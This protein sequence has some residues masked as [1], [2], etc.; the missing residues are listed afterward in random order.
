[1]IIQK[2][3]PRI[4]ITAGLCWQIILGLPL[5][6]NA[7]E[8]C[9]IGVATGKATADGRPL[10]WKT[11]DSG[12]Q[13]DNEV[14]YNS[15]N[16]YN[17]ISVNNDGAT[18]AWMG[19]N[20]KGFAIINSVSS[21][22]PGLVNSRGISNGKIMRDCLGSCATVAEFEAF[23]ILTNTTGRTSKANFGVIDS[24]GA[25]VI[26]ETSGYQFW[27]F[28]ANDTNL[29]KTGYIIRTNFSV[30]GGGTYSR[31]RFQRSTKLIGDFYSGD[32]LN[33]RSI[34]RYQ[35]RNFSDE[36]SNPITV[37]FTAKWYPS[38]SYRYGYLYNY[39]SI[40]RSTSVSAM[41]VQGVLPQ[42][43]PAYLSTMWTILGQP[44][45]GIAVPYWPVGT[46]PVVADGPVTAELCDVANEIR[47]YLYDWP[48]YSDF[49]DSYKLLDGSSGGLWKITLPVEDRIL[50]QTDSLLTIWRASP[51]VSDILLASETEFA[52]LAL[53]TLKAGRD[54]LASLSIVDFSGS[55]P[56][57]FSLDQN[58]PNPFNATT[59]IPFR[60]SEPAWITIKIHDIR[61]RQLVTLFEGNLPAGKYE[62]EWNSGDFSSGVYLYSITARGSSNSQKIFS[63]TGKLTLIK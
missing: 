56:E 32:S 48:G 24:T 51:P 23:L 63:D 43:E 20:E 2:N 30:T 25:A 50:H 19:V 4:L 41:V 22:L 35:M 31:E 54:Y 60:Q 17:F 18:Y 52:N 6:V 15:T 13:P 12:A 61:G 7:D 57:Q 21:D 49:L 16:L 46:T 55:A 28:D 33:H 26:F 40:C 8:E 27:K 5:N 1:M 38:P 37:P 34:L 58:F 44:A 47:T 10:I 29:T 62:V 14:K 9:T 53:T 45:T 59:K 39:L 42:G 36:D 11:R 3:L